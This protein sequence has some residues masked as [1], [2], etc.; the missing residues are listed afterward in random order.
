MLAG[1]E[2]DEKLKAN[3][4]DQ[5]FDIVCTSDTIKD[6]EVF[7]SRSLRLEVPFMHTGIKIQIYLVINTFFN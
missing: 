6:F 7:G 4:L 5:I 2:S 3:K 1:I